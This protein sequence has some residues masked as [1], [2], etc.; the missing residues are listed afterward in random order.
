[1]TIGEAEEEDR[2]LEESEEK[3]ENQEEAKRPWFTEI[4]FFQKNSENICDLFV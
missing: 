3:A 4:E 2:E 1:V